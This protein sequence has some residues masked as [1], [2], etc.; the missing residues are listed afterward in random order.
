MAWKGLET[1]LG[2]DPDSESSGGHDKEDDMMMMC[3]IIITHTSPESQPSHHVTA[4]CSCF[5]QLFTGQLCEPRVS[6]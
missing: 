3:L 4:S 2:S 5:L 6:C 1:K